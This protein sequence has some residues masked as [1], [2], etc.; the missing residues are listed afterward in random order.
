MA[1]SIQPD[2]PLRDDVASL[3][4]EHLADMVAISPPESRHALDAEGLSGPDISFWSARSGTELLGCV[5]LKTL[6]P[7]HG[8][9][10]SMRVASAARRRGVGREMLEFVLEE[11]RRRGLLRLSLETGAMVEIAPARSLYA[12]AGFLECGPFGPYREDPNSVF[13]TLSL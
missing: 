6:S 8:E 11:A 10:K 3:L 2:D 9:I 12:G 4:D 7:E 1:L 5:A 13:M